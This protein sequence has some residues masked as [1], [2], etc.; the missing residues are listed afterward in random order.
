MYLI[1]LFCSPKCTK[2]NI[3]LVSMSIFLS[4]GVWNSDYCYILRHR[5]DAYFWHV[6]TSESYLKLSLLLL[7][8]VQLKAMK[9]SSLLLLPCTAHIILWGIVSSCFSVADYCCSWEF[10]ETHREEQELLDAR[11]WGEARTFLK[12]LFVFFIGSAQLRFACLLVLLKISHE[13]I[14]CWP[15]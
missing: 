12:T 5:F 2:I 7:L 10:E 14:E 1:S 8:F 3:I 13:K 6:F 11:R 9:W 15:F 4:L